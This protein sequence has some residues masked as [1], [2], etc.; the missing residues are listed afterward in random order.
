MLL[1]QHAEQQ[2]AQNMAKWFG[3]APQQPLANMPGL[4]RGANVRS[5]DEIETMHRV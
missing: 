5:V 2:A 1:P 4:P 3:M